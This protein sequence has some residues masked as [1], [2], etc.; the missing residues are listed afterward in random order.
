L[1][2]RSLNGPVNYQV[3]L[4]P[5]PASTRTRRT[6]ANESR[7]VSGRITTLMGTTVVFQHISSQPYVC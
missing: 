2:T 6:S 4:N 7:P 3:N 1:G 5:T